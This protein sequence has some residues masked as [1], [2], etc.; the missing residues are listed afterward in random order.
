MDFRGNL[1]KLA[2]GWF[3][4]AASWV[5]AVLPL[6]EQCQLV[7]WQGCLVW[8]TVSLVL[9]AAFCLYDRLLASLFLRFVGE[10]RLVCTP[11]GEAPQ[12]MP[13]CEVQMLA[14]RHLEQYVDLTADRLLWLYEISASESGH[15]CFVRTL[16]SWHM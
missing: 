10:C 13:V 15:Q 7:S 4:L 5:G 1:S 2:S 11:V 14:A 9:P 12:G 16:M 8:V 3:T 6:L